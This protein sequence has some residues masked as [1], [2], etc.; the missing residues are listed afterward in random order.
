MK[1]HKFAHFLLAS[2]G[3]GLILYWFLEKIRLFDEYAN[4]YAEEDWL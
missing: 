2:L 3:F 4:D 1:K